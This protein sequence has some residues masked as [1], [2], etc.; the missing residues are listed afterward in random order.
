MSIIV[1]VLGLVVGFLLLSSLPVLSDENYFII[2]CRVTDGFVSGGIKLVTSNLY[3]NEQKH[4]I[5]VCRV[6]DE[7]VNG[8]VAL[9]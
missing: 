5:F 8:G 1:G 3:C 4:F 6:T 9:L 7:P 2:V